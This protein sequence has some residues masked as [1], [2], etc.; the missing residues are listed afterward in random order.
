MSFQGDR[1]ASHDHSPIAE[2][3]G[4]KKRTIL[5]VIVGMDDTKCD[6]LVECDVGVRATTPMEAARIVGDAM[7]KG[8]VLLR[9]TNMSTGEI[10]VVDWRKSGI[11]AE[12]ELE[13]VS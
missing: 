13:V 10:V 1:R 3:Q 4:G 7:R 5:G 12:Q 8:E 9:I 6:F 11:P 2:K